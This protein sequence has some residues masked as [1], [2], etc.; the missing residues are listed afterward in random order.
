MKNVLTGGL[1]CI[2]SSVSGRYLVLLLKNSL[3]ICFYF[4]F[5][6]TFCAEHPF[7]R[8]GNQHHLGCVV[9]VVGRQNCRWTHLTSELKHPRSHEMMI[10]GTG[11]HWEGCW[12]SLEQADLLTFYLL[13]LSYPLLVSLHKYISSTWTD[14]GEKIHNFIHINILLVCVIR[15]LVIKFLLEL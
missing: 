9:Q 12:C 5:K 2:F 7:H 4:I 6:K 11:V 3:C 13:S 1:K 15:G 14:L 8:G 10:W